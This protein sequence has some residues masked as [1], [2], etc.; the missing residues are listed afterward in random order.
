MTVPGQM[1]YAQAP[2][3]SC[4]FIQTSLLMVVYLLCAYGVSDH[5]M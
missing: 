3:L 2:A 4:N 1:C 5:G